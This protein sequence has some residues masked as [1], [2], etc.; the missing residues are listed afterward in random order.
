MYPVHSLIDPRRIFGLL[1]K[2]AQIMI[3]RKD[4]INVIKQWLLA[5]INNILQY[6]LN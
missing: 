1:N 4:N 5:I 2:N 3:Y 6:R